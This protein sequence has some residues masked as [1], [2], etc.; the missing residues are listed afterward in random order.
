MLRILLLALLVAACGPGRT[1]FATYPNA[2]TAFDR[3]GSD[4][5]ALEIAD[6]VFVA[7]GG[8]GNWEKAKQLRWKQ[9]VTADGKVTLDTEQAWDRWNGRHY[10]R[11]VRG[12]QHLIV[13]YELYGDFSMGF[14]EENEGK[15]KQNFDESSRT[16][17]VKLARENF[18]LHTSVLAVH[19]ML[20][21]PG[22]KLAYVGPAN[23]ESGNEKLDELK[24]TFDEPLRKES[25]F[26]LFVDRG[27]N[28]PHR[29][30][31]VKGTEKVGFT[32]ANWVTVGGMKFATTRGNLGYSG[33]TVAIKDIKV[34]DP[35][36]DLY[37][38]P[39][40]H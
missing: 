3:A 11:L 21:D 32:L 2:P 30:E 13:A 22:A 20:F 17:A 36:D 26:R 6:K 7:A 1:S 9:T 15:K 18:N 4:P 39:I 5:K 37:I 23:D 19:L 34:S 27:T 33:E 14:A 25:E 8:P 38:A 28:L 40:T 35:D 16:S 10:G 12:E 31:I 29:V 24:I